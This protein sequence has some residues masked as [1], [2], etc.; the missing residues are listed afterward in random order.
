MARSDRSP[1]G[2]RL[3]GLLAALLILPVLLGLCALLLPPQYEETFLG[4]MKDKLER[5][6]TTP[7]LSLIHISEPT[8][9]Y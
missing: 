1:L 9:P 3:F 5:L 7:G 6:R 2:R 4:E 8:R